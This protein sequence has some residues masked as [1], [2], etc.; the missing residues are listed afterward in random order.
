VP[1]LL[2]AV[3]TNTGS[4]HTMGLECASP[5]IGVFQ[6]TFEPFVASQLTGVGLPSPTP[7]AFG[8]RNEGQSRAQVIDASVRRAIIDP[9]FSMREVVS[10]VLEA[11]CFDIDCNFSRRTVNGY[12]C[13]SLGKIVVWS[14]CLNVN[15][16]TLFASTLKVT[17]MDS[18]G[19]IN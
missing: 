11:R 7:D 8:P 14:P 19:I 16:V 4:P 18:P 6:S 1:L 3:V 9:I 13:S 15:P 5:G 10:I 17:K 2:I 12:F